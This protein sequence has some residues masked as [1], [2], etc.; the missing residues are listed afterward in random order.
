MWQMRHFRLVMGKTVDKFEYFK[1][2]DVDG[3]IGRERGHYHIV[4][5]TRVERLKRKKGQR[6]TFRVTFPDRSQRGRLH[7]DLS[8]ENETDCVKWIE[9]LNRS[10][11]KAN[12]RRKIEQLQS[13]RALLVEENKTL[14]G[15][16]WSAGFAQRAN[17]GRVYDACED[18]CCIVEPLMSSRNDDD[19]DRIEETTTA[20]TRFSSSSSSYSDNLMTPGVLVK[21]PLDSACEGGSVDIVRR[22]RSARGRAGSKHRKKS[23]HLFEH[24]LFAVVA[25][26]H[27][28][29]E[30]ADFVAK[31]LPSIF[32]KVVL[33]AYDG[34]LASTNEKETF[35]VDNVEPPTPSV[36]PPSTPAFESM[37]P[38]HS[39]RAAAVAVAPT[40]SSTSPQF[41]SRDDG[42]SSSA[43]GDDGELLLL[44]KAIV[45]NSFHESFLRCDSELRLSR[46]AKKS[47]TCV[48]SLVVSREWVHVAHVG[49]CRAVALWQT[50][51][52]SGTVSKFV[53]EE[54]TTDHKPNVPAE[55]RR[56]RRCGGLVVNNRLDG[57]LAVSRSIGDFMFKRNYNRSLVASS[58]SFKF[59][60]LSSPEN[61]PSSAS[62]SA[63]DTH[64]SPHK[65][66]SASD[67]PN[68][69]TSSRGSGVPNWVGCDSP[70]DDDAGESPSDG[71]TMSPTLSSAEWKHGLHMRGLGM[72]K[73]M[74]ANFENVERRKSS[75]IKVAATWPTQKTKKNRNSAGA[76]DNGEKA[77]TSSETR[78]S[79][80]PDVSSFRRESSRRS[81]MCIVAASDGLWDVF[82]S[83]DAMLLVDSNLRSG[84]SPTKIA[85]DLVAEAQRRGSLDDVTAIVIDLAPCM[86]KGR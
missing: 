26:G 24:C 41:E 12:L 65:S 7:L 11:K 25:D 31:R 76:I 20:T 74:L 71:L 35:V 55:R 60:D 18:R 56:I 48:V 57:V 9:M 37:V 4:A 68:W 77:V 2:S 51:H 47:G 23:P 42:G 63:N 13:K 40:P 52:Q 85:T 27:G 15:R 30:S 14:M 17:C 6:L 29:S 69:M 83:R 33:S 46:L 49:D 62:E 19:D 39:N 59:N 21:S 1:A 45:E 43:P 67:I 61:V 84:H 66:R 64:R 8:T 81:C 32:R 50:V 3:E 72:M 73:I 10:I 44:D 58:D 54:L 75:K 78:V 28:G 82:D 5:G 80:V 38:R 79:A 36:Y 22:R 53:T 34:S 16:I 70:E 86:R